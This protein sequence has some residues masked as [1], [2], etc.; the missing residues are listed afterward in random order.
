MDG[1]EENRWGGLLL[2]A[3]L[4]LSARHVAT[5]QQEGV[6]KLASLQLPATEYQTQ[7]SHPCVLHQSSPYA[8]HIPPTPP[9]LPWHSG[10]VVMAATNLPELLDSALTRPGRF[11]RQV[12]ACCT[13]PNGPSRS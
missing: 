5:G 9:H 13:L 1:F 10:I 6:R 4:Q 3:R 12:G 8:P 11:D 2:R 7:C